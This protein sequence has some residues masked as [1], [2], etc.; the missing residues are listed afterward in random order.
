MDA[1][2]VYVQSEE[3]ME[4]HTDVRHQRNI[5]HII[6]VLHPSW[7]LTSGCRVDANLLLFVPRLLILEKFNEIYLL[8]ILQIVIIGCLRT[9]F[10]A[11]SWSSR[12]D[13]HH[14]GIKEYHGWWVQLKIFQ[15]R[16]HRIN[17]GRW[18]PMDESLRF[19]STGKKGIWSVVVQLFTAVS[20]RQ[21][22]PPGQESNFSRVIVNRMYTISGTHFQS[23]RRR[24]N[25]IR[26]GIISPCSCLVADGALSKMWLL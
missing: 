12:V 14:S 17:C 20:P 26:N 18:K 4:V 15:M 21:N 23:V 6:A 2:A 25:G 7:L 16:S 9:I 13:L 22:N 8:F 5:T 1:L 24:W 19:Q 10:M 3:Y 11:R